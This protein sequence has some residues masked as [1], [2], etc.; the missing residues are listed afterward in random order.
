[1]NAGL[2]WRNPT[3]QRTASQLFN[4]PLSFPSTPRVSIGLTNVNVEDIAGGNTVGLSVYAD[5]ISG[6]GFMLNLVAVGDTLP[7]IIDGVWIAIPPYAVKNGIQYQTGQYSTLQTRE[8]GP[9]VQQTMERIYFPY[10]FSSSPQ[11]LVW[12]NGFEF[13]TNKNWRIKTYATDI[14]MTGFVIHVDTWNDTQL[15]VGNVSWLAYPASATNAVSGFMRPANVHDLGGSTWAD[16]VNVDWP[17]EKKTGQTPTV[18][19]GY[20]GFEED[21]NSFLR[22]ECYGNTTAA[23]M[24]RQIGGAAQSRYRDGNVSYLAIF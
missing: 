22:F 15:W 1:M 13:S 4:F 10:K 18:L 16:I 21:N 20:S 24:V 6:D 5:A 12:I 14:D 7:H 8:Q 23:G 9:G 2:D 19:E 17:I 3:G 11:I